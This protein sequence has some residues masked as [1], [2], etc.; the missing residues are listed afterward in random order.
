VEVVDRTTNR[1]KH[2]HLTIPI[3]KP[4]FFCQLYF[5]SSMQMENECEMRNSCNRLDHALQLLADAVL[6]T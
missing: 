3:R 1:N 2:A 5:Q 6:A 4:S